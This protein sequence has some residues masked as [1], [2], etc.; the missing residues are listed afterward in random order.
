MLNTKIL[1]NGSMQKVDFQGCKDVDLGIWDLL[2]T[3]RTDNN[4]VSSRCRVDSE[5]RLQHN[6]CYRKHFKRTIHAMKTTIKAY[7]H[8]FLVRKRFYLPITTFPPFLY[9]LH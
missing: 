6:T 5:H 7:F 3:S 9:L 2:R 1:L 8:P 4:Y